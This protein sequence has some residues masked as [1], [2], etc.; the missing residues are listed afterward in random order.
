MIYA[1]KVMSWWSG[2]QY[3]LHKL[4]YHK[5]DNKETNLDR[6]ELFCAIIAWFWQGTGEMN[7]SLCVC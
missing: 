2:T 4:E 3:S 6:A 7:A 5:K 1:T